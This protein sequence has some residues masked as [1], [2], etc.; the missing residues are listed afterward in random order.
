MDSVALVPPSRGQRSEH[1]AECSQSGSRVMGRVL[2]FPA[3]CVSAAVA[4]HPEF[5]LDLHARGMKGTEAMSQTMSEHPQ[6]WMMVMKMRAGLHCP[7]AGGNS[8]DSC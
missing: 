1:A 5:W 2:C 3:C 8:S 6:R 4:H 7:A